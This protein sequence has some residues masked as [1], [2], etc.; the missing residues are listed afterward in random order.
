MKKISLLLALLLIF[1]GCAKTSVPSVTP[2]LPPEPTP[3]TPPSFENPSGIYADWSKLQKPENPVEIG[4]RLHEGPLTELIPS[5]DYGILVPYV[6]DVVTSDAGGFFVSTEYRYGLMTMDGCVVLDPVLSAVYSITTDIGEV[7][8]L[9]KPVGEGENMY[10]AEALC[11][12]DGSWCTDFIYSGTYWTGEYLRAFCLDNNNESSLLD[13]RGNKILGLED[14]EFEIPLNKDMDDWMLQY[15]ALNFSGG[16]VNLQL[17]DGY[18]AYFDMQGKVLRSDEFNGR[19]YSTFGFFKDGVAVVQPL[20][21]IY[22]GILKP[23]GTWL[24]HP[25]SGNNY[26]EALMQ[27]GGFMLRDEDG[28]LTAFDGKGNV[29]CNKPQLSRLESPE[30]VELSNGWC[31]SAWKDSTNIIYD[32]DL[33]ELIIPVEDSWADCY[34]GY[35]VGITEENGLRGLKIYDGATE[36]FIPGEFHYQYYAYDYVCAVDSDM[37][38][39]LFDTKGN[40]LLQQA[41]EDYSV[42]I[43]VDM[44]TKE[45]YLAI[46]ANSTSYIA[47]DGTK[48]TNALSSIRNGT[49]IVVDATGSGVKNLQGEYI[50]RK[51]IDLT[52]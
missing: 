24:V 46:W 8:V 47:P 23:D 29:I 16:Y 33:N 25:D 14:L 22:Y 31:I 52:D 41:V 35:A 36:V 4:S 18:Y 7:Y 48:L 32:L 15:S 49:Y 26:C 19:S 40:T 17:E 37:T 44:V 2:A 1:S 30:L 12:M 6:G 20:T 21:S 50:F 28:V 38:A 42:G 51:Q 3:G 10:Q 11:A 27:F 39:Y 43:N 45:P 34:G 13:S 5:D 9:D